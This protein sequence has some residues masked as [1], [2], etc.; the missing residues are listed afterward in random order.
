M[1][2]TDERRPRREA[3]GEDALRRAADTLDETKARL[4]QTSAELHERGREL[5]R[6]RNLVRDIARTTRELSAAKPRE[7]PPASTPASDDDTTQ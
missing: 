4:R 1:D 7:D 2:D 3:T 6:T 5:D